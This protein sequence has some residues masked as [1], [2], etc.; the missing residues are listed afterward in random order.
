MPFWW[1]AEYMEKIVNYNPNS[2]FSPALLHESDLGWQSNEYAEILYAT[3]GSFTLSTDTETRT[4]GIGDGALIMPYA[5]FK[6]EISSDCSYRIIL[7]SPDFFQN[8]CGFLDG[9]MYDEWKAQ[10]ICYFHMPYNDVFLFEN[11][12]SLFVR[13]PDVATRKRIEKCLTFQLI[14]LL[15]SMRQSERHDDEFDTFYTLCV[16]ILNRCCTSSSYLLNLQQAVGYHKV[17]LCK[18]FK[19][20]FGTTIS[21]YVKNLRLQY[22]EYMLKTTALSAAQIAK[23][24]GIESFSYFNK[25][26]KEQYGVTPTEFRSRYKSAQA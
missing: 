21:Q 6:I 26:F 18:K 8:C 24:A 25:I 2:P 7:F 19:E 14:G 23:S 9:E 5:K 16:D 13:E 20:V 1:Y 4:F 17:Y 10:R 22:A 3:Q 11:R 15:L 12:L